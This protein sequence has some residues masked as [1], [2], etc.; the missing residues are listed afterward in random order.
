MFFKA[1][2]AHRCPPSRTSGMNIKPIDMRLQFQLEERSNR[3]VHFP[4]RQKRCTCREVFHFGPSESSDI[5]CSPS[6]SPRHYT[7]TMK[8]TRTLPEHFEPP[9]PSL[10]KD[11]PSYLTFPEYLQDRAEAGV[12]PIIGSSRDIE[13]SLTENARP[14]IMI[15]LRSNLPRRRKCVAH[16][17]TDVLQVVI[18]AHPQ[19][20]ARGRKHAPDR[21]P[22]G[23]LREHGVPWV[24]QMSLPAMERSHSD[25]SFQ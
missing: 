24:V 17:S 9:R 25:R 19:C 1:P 22:V 8:P 10:C 21:G 3:Q 5:Q 13:E 20:F 14:H 11:V 16:M 2:P 6:D 12:A 15:S 23:R 7:D 4:S 18:A